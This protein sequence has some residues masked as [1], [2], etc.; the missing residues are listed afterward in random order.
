MRLI[1]ADALKKDA[2]RL[3]DTYEED[4]HEK[5]TRINAVEVA[6]IDAAPT[7]NN[8]IILPCNIGDTIYEACFLK[9]GTGSHIAE[10][11]CCGIHFADK[12]TRWRFEKP[13]R[14]LTLKTHEGH[15]IRVRM[16]EFRK[17]LFLTYDEAKAALQKKE[18]RHHDD[19]IR[20]FEPARQ[21]TKGHPRY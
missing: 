18:R 19:S 11:I 8:V 10:Y 2:R 21:A 5:Y 17:T 14:Y 12:V 9:D 3:I 1:D 16:D 6:A 20:D 7:I 4:G 13:V 15:S